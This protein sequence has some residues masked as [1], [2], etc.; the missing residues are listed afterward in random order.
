LFLGLFLF[1]LGIVM[2]IKSDLGTM[3]WDAFHLGVA[4]YMPLT[5]GEVSQLTGAIII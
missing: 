1:G 3:P 4:N 2:T 5:F